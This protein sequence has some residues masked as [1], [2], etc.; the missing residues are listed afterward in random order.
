MTDNCSSKTN[1]HSA[2]VSSVL[3]VFVV[4]S[5]IGYLT[6]FVHSWG[7][8]PLSDLYGTMLVFLGVIVL[9]ALLLYAIARL[10]GLTSQRLLWV[11]LIFLPANLFFFAHVLSSDSRAVFLSGTLS[12][13]LLFVLVC[14]ARRQ[15]SIALVI[16]LLHIVF[17]STVLAH[18]AWRGERAPLSTFS[19]DTVTTNEHPTRSVYIIGIDSMVSRLAYRALFDAAGSPAYSWLDANG[20]DLYD[21]RS[22]GDQ[23]LTT[24]GSLLSQ[25]STVHPRT[26]RKLFNGLQASPLYEFLKTA[27]FKRQF[28]YSN[29]YFGQDE[30]QIESFFPKSGKFSFCAYADDRWG[31]Y[32]CR[33]YRNLAGEA[34]VTSPQVQAHYEFWRDQV[35]LN[36][37]ERWFS[38]HHI[39]YPGHTISPYDGASLEH[40]QQFRDYFVGAQKPLAQLLQQITSHIHLRDP[41]AVVVFFGDHG[42]FLLRGLEAG[43]TVTDFFTPVS[44]GLLDMDSR[45]VLLAV[46]PLGFCRSELSRMSDSALML[47][48]LAECARQ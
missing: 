12:Y 41:E 46:R 40:R 10:L 42:A 28:F 26:V 15:T 38:I 30:G 20:F 22:P 9:Q 2:R 39:W 31:Y 18:Q 34:E 45:S 27:G 47:R 44:S 35:T 13:C 19:A 37:S 5:L 11:C 16:L 4:I 32:F 23:T 48:V 8:Y 25:S 7:S 17:W 6:P 14:R 3:Q 29:D 43:S 24:Y 36:P 33:L 1:G 21:L